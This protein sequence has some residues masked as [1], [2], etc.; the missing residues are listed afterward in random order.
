M[1]SIRLFCLLLLSAFCV[2]PLPAQ[3]IKMYNIQLDG[4]RLRFSPDLSG[5]AREMKAAI[6]SGL[7]RLAGIL[8]SP[9]IP[10]G[11]VFWLVTDEEEMHAVL[12]E[13]IGIH[14]V[15]Q[16]DRLEQTIYM[17]FYQ[18]ERHVVLRSPATTPLDWH[19]RLL[20]SRYAGMLLDSMTPGS[21]E[22]RV[23]WL[24]AGLTGY[25]AWQ[26]TSEYKNPGMTD[27]KDNKRLFERRL[28]QY[29]RQYFNPDRAPSL[30]ALGE[31]EGWRKAVRLSPAQ[32]QAQSILTYL[33][34]S[35][36]TDPLVGVRLLRIYE[37]DR[38]FGTA[39]KR[40]TGMD[41]VDFEEEVRTRFYP[42][43]KQKPEQ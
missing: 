12:T 5:R 26:V 6:N 15:R 3:S 4:C 17:G 27:G 31:E 30:Q 19:L 43:Y 21:N 7:R 11:C 42:L 33:Y 32:V 34:L 9:G 18:D 20:F 40:A 22:R 24:Y 23:G 35:L 41:L 38:I 2:L 13:A 8:E 36:K 29:Y 14:P 39:F 25:L 10:D 16:R 37:E 28:E 1:F